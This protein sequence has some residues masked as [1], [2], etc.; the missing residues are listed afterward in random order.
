MPEKTREQVWATWISKQT[1]DHFQ[2]MLSAQTEDAKYK[3]LA[4]LLS[5]EPEKTKRKSGW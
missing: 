4:Q 5:D 2:E 3:I 1:D